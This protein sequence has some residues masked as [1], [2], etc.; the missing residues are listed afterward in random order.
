MTR[1]RLLSAYLFCWLVVSVA[2][3][4]VFVASWSALAASLPLW[5]CL[6][7]TG[8]GILRAL[9]LAAVWFW[10]RTGVIANI[11]LTVV[12]I[13]ISLALHETRGVLGAVALLVLLLL[14]RSKWQ[15]MTWSISSSPRIQT[16]GALA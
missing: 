9:S 12:T 1:G 5:A 16:G 11:V 15:H 10:S 4:G 7:L 13:A 2:S 14:V 8:I 3:V 6:A